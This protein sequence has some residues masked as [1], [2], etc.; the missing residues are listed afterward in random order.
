M[1]T[2]K[3]LLFAVVVTF[4]WAIC[5]P[6]IELG[7]RAAPPLKFAAI[8]SAIAGLSLVLPLIFLRR[9]RFWNSKVIIFS[10]FVSITHTVMG[11]GGMFL[12]DGRIA[13]GLAT[14][15]A[16]T[17]PLIAAVLAY[18]FLKERLS[19]QNLLG[20]I[21]GFFGIVIIAFPK[22]LGDASSQGFL[23]IGYILVGALGTGA[24]NV[25]MKKSTAECDLLQLTGYQLS[26]GGLV[27][28]ILSLFFEPQGQI[29]WHSSFNWSLII[30][31]IPG[32]SLTTVI[33]I[34]LLKNVSLTKL[35][36]FTLL[37]PAFGMA[38]GF[39]FFK[40]RFSF[41]ELLGIVFAL[42][43]VYLATLEKKTIL[44]NREAS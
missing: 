32:T 33:W 30:L 42:G 29:N 39:L 12:A 9:I 27:L 37:T 25:I 8:R 36:V 6:L 20:L 13:P 2:T 24:G 28:F 22:F 38:I 40:E 26:I 16:N 43:G 44:N 3:H 41:I 11:F 35:N 21:I 10:F 15:L 31:A 18:Y 23:G 34:N 1:L 7:H 4:F 19:L 14:V 5:F 17:Q